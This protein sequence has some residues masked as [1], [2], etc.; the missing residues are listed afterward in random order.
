MRCNALGGGSGGKNEA[1]GVNDDPEIRALNKKI[2]KRRMELESGDRFTHLGG[3][4]DHD[5]VTTGKS[6]DAPS[7]GSASLLSTF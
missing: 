7:F 6:A 2:E 1:A 4:A 3:F 5:T